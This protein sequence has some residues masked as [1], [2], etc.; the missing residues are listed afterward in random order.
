MGA[1]HRIT[2]YDA[3]TGRDGTFSGPLRCLEYVS[4]DTTG[5]VRSMVVVATICV[6]CMLGSLS[7]GPWILHI[8]LPGWDDGDDMQTATFRTGTLFGLV[9]AMRSLTYLKHG[10][11][12]RRE[13]NELD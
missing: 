3:A 8:T 6:A 7:R 12:A 5:D 4:D 11:I 1:M 9:N 13:P 10:S 2:R